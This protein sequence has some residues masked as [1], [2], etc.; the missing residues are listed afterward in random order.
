MWANQRLVG[1]LICLSHTRPN[2][3]I[4]AGMTNQYMNSPCKEHLYIVYGIVGSLKKN[5]S[6]ELFFKKKIRTRKFKSTEMQL[7]RF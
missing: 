7:G 2:I 6:I 3:T 4:V 1:R 5:P